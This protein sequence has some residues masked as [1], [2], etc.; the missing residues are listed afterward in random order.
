MLEPCSQYHFI[1][2][3][4]SVFLLKLSTFNVQEFV[5]RQI[6]VDIADGR[7]DNKSGRGRGRGGGGGMGGRGGGG[8]TFL[9]LYVSYFNETAG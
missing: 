5:D 2:A 6:R 1:V 4:N 8:M 7:K 9:F 3:R